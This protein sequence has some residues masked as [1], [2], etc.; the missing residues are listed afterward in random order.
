MGRLYTASEFLTEALL[1]AMILF[2]AWAF[3]ATENW[4]VWTLNFVAYALGLLLIVKKAAL[5]AS[6]I[7]PPRWEDDSPG[8]N[9]WVTAMIAS[10][11]ALLAYILAGALNNR[12][13]FQRAERRFI[14]RESIPWL[15]HSYDAIS[16][17]YVFWYVLGLSCVFWSARHWLLGKSRV[18][19]VE[20]GGPGWCMP[21]RLRRLLW[22]L[23]L[24]G[25]ALAI[26]G[27]VQ[28]LE[29]SG[30]LLFII[31]PGWNADAVQQ[32]GPWAYRGN[33]A[34]YFNLLWPVVIGFWLWLSSGSGRHAGRP[35]R[36]GSDSRI[37][38]LPLALLIASC[39]V[40]SS[41]RTGTIIA[42]LMAGATMVF[43]LMSRRRASIVSRL[44]VPL[45]I[46]LGF[47]LGL[48][49]GWDQLMSR[50][51]ESMRGDWSTRPHVYKNALRML[52]DFYVLGSGAGTFGPIYQLYR[53]D[54]EEEWV[55]YAHN[56]WLE[57]VITLGVPGV[58]V[59][60]LSFL[61]LLA[62][63]FKRRGLQA[64][65]VFHAFILLSIAGCLVQAAIDFP[66]QVYSIQFIFILFCSVLSCCGNRGPVRTAALGG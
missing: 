66:L 23:S 28:R 8:R 21:A 16:S 62:D 31:K 10:N 47:A 42:T 52:D 65:R 2:G 54:P 51:Q 11:T 50:T 34:E 3:G 14:F 43:V 32:F 29:G 55:A 26:E 58:T 9:W 46:G 12:A 61:S 1:Y 49:F 45:T 57:A 17:L 25:A 41:S 27:I 6:K 19:S 5:R 40:I 64:P 56:D 38:L 48:F 60:G 4:S 13:T 22:V 59:L 53:S 7:R 39:P 18:E 33:A 36:F 37:I 44:A 15:P 30:R 20:P 24:N 35:R 63:S